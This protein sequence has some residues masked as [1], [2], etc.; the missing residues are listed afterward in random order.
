MKDVFFSINSYKKFSETVEI[1]LEVVTSYKFSILHIHDVQSI[2]A[3]KEIQHGPYKIVEFCRGPSA[4]KMLDINP[5]IGLFLPCKIII[6]EDS[7]KVI[8]KVLRP[9]FIHNF[10]PDDDLGNIPEKVDSDIEVLVKTLEER[11]RQ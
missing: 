9:N 4:K 11:I 3:K 8:V 10:F 6:Y 7:T 2:F 1:A 5:V